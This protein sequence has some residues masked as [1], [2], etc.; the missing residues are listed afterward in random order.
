MSVVWTIVVA[1]GSGH[2]FGQRKQF[3]ELS[4]RPVVAHSVTASSAV[5][6]GVV[7][8]VPVDATT[9]GAYGAD[10][11]VGGGPTRS[12]SVRQGLAAV[13]EA[14]DVI[15]VHDAAR[16][17]ATVALFHAVIDAVTAGADAAVPGVPVSD[18]LKQV[19]ADGTVVSTVDRSAL[20]GVQTPQ[21]FR[22]DVLRRAHANEDDATD[23]AALVEALGGTVLVVA[24]DAQNVKI[25]TPDDL[26]QAER[27]LRER[28]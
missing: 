1:G 8:V 9:D 4:G 6:D 16:P 26:R 24:G 15:V 14:A 19:D 23:D 7:L 21:A 13:P 25:T 5:S 10:A 28:G 18:T 11:V 22:A 3:A 2:R 12:A 20:V 27:L 17:L